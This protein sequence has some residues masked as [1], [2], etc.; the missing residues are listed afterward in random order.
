[1]VTIIAG[2]ASAGVSR[3]CLPASDFKCV[4][5]ERQ[6][7]YRNKYKANYYIYTENGL[8]NERLNKLISLDNRGLP[9]RVIYGLIRELNA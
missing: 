9:V 2:I 1:M 4:A 6:S 3:N 7:I 8:L 5:K